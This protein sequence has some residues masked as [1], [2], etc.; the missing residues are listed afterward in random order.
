MQRSVVW[1]AVVFLPMCGDVAW[2]IIYKYMCL[3]CG[4]CRPVVLPA[5]CD[6]C[7][8]WLPLLAFFVHAFILPLAVVVHFVRMMW[9]F[10]MNNESFFIDFIPVYRDYYLFLI[11][12]PTD[13]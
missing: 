8:R 11:Y 9:F 5:S 10:V 4:I 6:G 12:L 7:A 1:Q 3:C 2:K 13:G